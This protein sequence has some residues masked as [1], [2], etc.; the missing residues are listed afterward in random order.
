MSALH[1]KA[2]LPAAGRRLQS[3]VIYSVRPSRRFYALRFNLHQQLEE[4]RRLE[5][6][7]RKASRSRGAGISLSA[8]GALPFDAIKID[9]SFTR[10]LGESEHSRPMVRT[11]TALA[12]TFKLDV[13]VEGVETGEQRR[14]VCRLGAHGLQGY[15]LSHLLP[16]SVAGTFIFGSHPA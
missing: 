14:I 3:R 5:A 16:A 11:I 2:C 12:K 8:G 10:G 15:L 4:N 1:N 9:Q 13:I 7:L 6:A